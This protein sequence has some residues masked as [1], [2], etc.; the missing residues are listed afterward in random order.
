[1]YTRPLLLAAASAAVSLTLSGQAQASTLPTPTVTF[2]ELDATFNDD[3]NVYSEAGFDFD[4]TS[5]QVGNCSPFPT[6]NDPCI[7]E[8]Q[9]TGQITTMTSSSGLPID[10]YGFYFDMQGTGNPDSLNQLILSSSKTTEETQF[11]FQL[12]QLAPAGSQL[13]FPYTFED[14][15]LSGDAYNG[16]IVNNDSYYVVIDS[17][18]FRGVDFVTW[19]TRQAQ[20]VR[21]DD[22]SAA[23]IPLPAAGW[24]LLAGVGGLAAMRR[25]KAA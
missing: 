13:Y 1:M 12:G 16:V 22:I 2:T 7:K 19:S 23:V 18:L 21:I 10:L 6:A 3:A 5:F 25:K 8:V 9:Q 11:V 17:P 15:V 14:G 4:P 24:L 20:N